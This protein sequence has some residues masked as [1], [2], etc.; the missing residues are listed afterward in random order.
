[1]SVKSSIYYHSPTGTHLYEEVTTEGIRSDAYIELS[2][3]N[4]FRVEKAPDAG[5]TVSFNIPP[6]IMDDLALAWCKR[7]KLRGALGGPVGK[8]FGSSESDYQ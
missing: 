3:P 6:E 1:M 4:E 2:N 7:R 5:I 8:E